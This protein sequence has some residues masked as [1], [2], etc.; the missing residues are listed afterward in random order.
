MKTKLKDWL[1]VKIFGAI[2]GIL[3]NTNISHGLWSAI[4]ISK[5]YPYAHSYVSFY[6]DSIGH[7]FF[8]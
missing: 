1:L 8:R 7:R 3:T 2:A 5:T 4:S 6:V